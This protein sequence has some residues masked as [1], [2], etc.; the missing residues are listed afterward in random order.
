MSALKSLRSPFVSS[1]LVSLIFALV[2]FLAAI[3]LTFS[4]LNNRALP[5][6]IL[7]NEV[8]ADYRDF[9]IRGKRA[10]LATERN[11]ARFFSQVGSEISKTRFEVENTLLDSKRDTERFVSQVGAD[12]ANPGS[13]FLS[14]AQDGTQSVFGSVSP[15][16]GGTQSGSSYV[17]SGQGSS[18]SSGQ[19]NNAQTGSQS[20]SDSTYGGGGY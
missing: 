19:G 14:S 15:G 7:E 6:G 13:N 16:Q 12:V 9:I 2:S 11:T 8:S 3:G 4:H 20:G 10:L 17:S 5:E 18:V 1:I